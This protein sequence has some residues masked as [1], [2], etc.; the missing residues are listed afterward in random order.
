VQRAAKRRQP[1]DRRHLDAPA[2]R[3]DR[4]PRRRGIAASTVSR[5]MTA[6]DDLCV[7]A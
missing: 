5:D 1:A 6:L 2:G 7:S 3:C 4:Y